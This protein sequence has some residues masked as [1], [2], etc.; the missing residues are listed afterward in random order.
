MGISQTRRTLAE[1]ETNSRQRAI[2]FSS[3]SVFITALFSA[4]QPNT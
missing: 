2:A 4:E 1:Q 3:V